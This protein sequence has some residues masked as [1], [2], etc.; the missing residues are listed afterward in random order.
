MICTGMVAISRRGVTGLCQ[1]QEFQGFP[2]FMVAARLQ[3]KESCALATLFLAYFEDC[4][5]GFLRDVDLA[6]ALHVR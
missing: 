5:E 4:E 1:L 6:D 3:I 2:Q